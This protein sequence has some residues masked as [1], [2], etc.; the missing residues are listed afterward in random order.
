[1]RLGSIFNWPEARASRIS[2]TRATLTSFSVLSRLERWRAA[3]LRSTE[4]RPL[5]AAPDDDTPALLTP[6]VRAPATGP[7]VGFFKEGEVIFK[8]ILRATSGSVLCL[9]RT[10]TADQSR[11]LGLVP[12]FATSVSAR[13]WR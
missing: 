5:A 6:S 9:L 12:G 4:E 10:F 13:Y 11:T 1:M 7:V 3:A 2:C 8:R